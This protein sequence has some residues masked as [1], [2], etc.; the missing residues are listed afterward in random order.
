[1]SAHPEY[2]RGMRSAVNIVGQFIADKR[3]IREES[4]PDLITLRDGLST[5]LAIAELDVQ[6]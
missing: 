5:G 4:V 3:Y 1:M 2:L 6:Q